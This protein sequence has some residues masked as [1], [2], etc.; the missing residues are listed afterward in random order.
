MS[1]I[2]GN[3]LSNS[4][5]DGSPFKIGLEPLLNL[6]QIGNA[7][8]DVRLGYDFLV[9]VLSR[10]PYIP[11][12][13]RS[14]IRRLGKH[15]QETRRDLGDRFV[16]YPSQLVLATSLEYLCLP[17][18]VYTDILTRSSYTRLGIHMNTMVQPGFRGSIPLE[19]FNHS[20]NPIE[21]IVGAR[22]C[23]ARFFSVEDELNYQNEGEPRKYNADVRPTLSKARNDDDLIFLKKIRTA[24]IRESNN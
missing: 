1:L 17:D 3:A 14:G 24:R 12:E 22:I 5:L 20:N 15:F 6:E 19:L 16:V 10:Q 2:V 11:I 13:E 7:T 8:V 9:S 4:I 23:Q 18:N 21:L